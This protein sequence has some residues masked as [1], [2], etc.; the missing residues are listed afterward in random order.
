M[1]EPK[2]SFRRHVAKALPDFRKASLSV[3]NEGPESVAHFQAVL[4][5]SIEAATLRDI[6]DQLQEPTTLDGRKLSEAE[7]QAYALAVN[8]ARG[9][10]RQPEEFLK[11]VSKQARKASPRFFRICVAAMEAV[12]AERD[13]KFTATEGHRM[14]ALQAKLELERDTGEE[15]TQKQVKQ[16]AFE[17]VS[18]LIKN[19]NQN[20][21]P[22]EPENKRWSKILKSVSLDYLRPGV[23]GK[24]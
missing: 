8:F 12:R 4:N 7:V 19:R 6:F 16:R 23:K 10:A 5:R 22:L 20:F 21:A 1:N 15:P 11:L 14:A 3:G 9:T 18:L 2:K 17:I 13:H 24:S